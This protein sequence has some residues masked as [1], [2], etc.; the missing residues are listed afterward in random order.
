MTD[1]LGLAVS[2]VKPSGLEASSIPKNPKEFKE[3][4]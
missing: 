3:I 1:R 2:F 4:Q